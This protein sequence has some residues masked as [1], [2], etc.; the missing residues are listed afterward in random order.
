MK[1]KLLI[2]GGQGMLGNMLVDYFLESG[3]CHLFYTTRDK[4]DPKGLYLDAEDPILL[5]K[6]IEAVSPDIAVNCMGILNQYAQA[7]PQ[8]AFWV[9]GLVPHRI[10]QS[11]DRIGG[12]LIHISTDCVF[13]GEEGG[14]TEFAEPDGTSVYAKSKALGEVK[15]APHLTIRTSIIGP[16]IRPHGIGLLQWFLQQQGDISG[17]SQAFWNGVT[18]LEL[19]KCIRHVMEEEPLSGLLHVTAPQPINKYE[20]LQLFQFVFQKEDVTIHKDETVKLNRTLQ[21]TRTDF[22]YLVPGYD[23]MLHELKSW[24]CS[25]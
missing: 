24:M 17:Y 10:Q 9:N 12:K 15:A 23:A 20:L 4:K 18:T 25:H 1:R 13:S 19:A 8:Q 3:D 14:H 16:E 5:D 7:N 11:M 21:Q 22:H 6:V 2:L